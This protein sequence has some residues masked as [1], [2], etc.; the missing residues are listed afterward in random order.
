MIKIPKF[1]LGR[2][3]LT[4]AEK[5][6]ELKRLYKDIDGQRVAGIAAL[7]PWKSPY[8]IKLIAASSSFHKVWIV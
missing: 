4:E 5:D 7:Y 8:E 6:A 3:D 1:G 2:T